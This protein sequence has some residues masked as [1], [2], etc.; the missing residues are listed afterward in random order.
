MD[1]I[2]LDIPGSYLIKPRVHSDRRGCFVKTLVASKLAEFG[3]DVGFVEQY[4]SVSKANVI[5]GMHFQ[6]P[7]H[8]HFKLVYCALGSVTDVFLDL[9]KESVTYAKYFSLQLGS[10]TGHV[11]Y[12]PKGIAHG[13]AVNQAPALM[14]YNLTSEYAP[15]FDA[16][17]R[18]DSFGYDWGVSHAVMSERDVNFPPLTCFES[19]F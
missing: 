8:D 12:L 17:I 10:D 9:R 5:R 15:E 16:G 19:P 4:Y 13:F 18:W 6:L 11:L 3:L 1:I 14:V 2:E 7:P